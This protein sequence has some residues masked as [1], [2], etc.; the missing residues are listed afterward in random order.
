MPID[1]KGELLGFLLAAGSKPQTVGKYT[2]R[3]KALIPRTRMSDSD[4]ARRGL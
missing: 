3:G 4:A 2:E 1:G